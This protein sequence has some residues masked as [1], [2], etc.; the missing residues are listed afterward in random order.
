MRILGID[1]GG[2]TGIVN[3]ELSEDE[4]LVLLEWGEFTELS[5]IG[6]YVRAWAPFG[7][8]LILEDF[9]DRAN[10]FTADAGSAHRPIGMIQ[11][12]QYDEGF[13]LEM[14]EPQARLAITDEIMTEAGYWIVGGE[15]HARQALKHVLARCERKFHMPTMNQLH[16]R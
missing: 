1:P 15:G 4:P 3:C 2:T 13:K 12:L 16:P 7:D 14:P 9:V 8:L 5:E 6:E 11:W 10:N